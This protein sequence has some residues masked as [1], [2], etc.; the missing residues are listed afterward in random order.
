MYCNG[1]S[2]PPSHARMC[3]A[4]VGVP[5]CPLLPSPPTP[6][7]PGRFGWTQTIRCQRGRSPPTRSGWIRSG[8]IR[9]LPHTDNCPFNCRHLKK[10]HRNGNASSVHP[11]IRLL[12]SCPAPSNQ[13]D[14]AQRR[15]LGAGE[16]AALASIRDTVTAPHNTT[17]GRDYV[18]SLRLCL[19]G[20]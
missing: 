13:V 1:R 6:H 2:S 19:H 11:S 7:P 10:H 9:T 18:K 15:R 5:R 17:S 8:R 3:S 16:G 4:M 12:K 14:S 20:T